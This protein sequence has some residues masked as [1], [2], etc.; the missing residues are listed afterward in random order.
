MG[1]RSASAVNPG[2]A[3]GPFAEWRGSILDESIIIPT[4]GAWMKALQ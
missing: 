4:A 1:Y 2:L 3:D